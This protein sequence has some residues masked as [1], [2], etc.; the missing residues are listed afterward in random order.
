MLPQVMPAAVQ[1]LSLYCQNVVG[2]QMSSDLQRQA[3]GLHIVVI[4]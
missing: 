1:V 2:V 4:L 3:Q